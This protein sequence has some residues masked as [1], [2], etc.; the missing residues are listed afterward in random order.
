MILF[1]TF[2]SC[3]DK[4]IKEEEPRI[5]IGISLGA[6]KF[7]TAH[8]PIA[9]FFKNGVR[10]GGISDSN[11]G[12]NLGWNSSDSNQS[13]YSKG[14]YPDSIFVEWTDKLTCNRYEGGLKLPSTFVNN[15]IS[16]K[17]KEKYNSFNFAINFAPWEQFLRFFKLH[18]N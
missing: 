16:N 11:V 9:S 2:L 1:T 7:Y 10:I 12:D 17:E 5:D 4:K 15:Y 18:R 13:I 14:N 8:Y 6:P 3:K